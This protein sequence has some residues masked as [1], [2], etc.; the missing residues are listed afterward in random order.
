MTRRRAFRRFAAAT[1]AAVLAMVATGARA[2]SGLSSPVDAMEGLGPVEHHPV[3]NEKPNQLYHVLVRAPES[4]PAGALYPTVYPAGRRDH[5]PPALGVLP[6]PAPGG[7]G[8]RAD[9]RGHLVRDRRLARR[10]RAQPRLHGPC[11]GR[12]PLGWCGGVPGRAQE[13]DL[14]AG[15]ERVPVGSGAPHRLRPVAGRTV[16]PQCRVEGPRAVLGPRRQQP[17]AAPQPGALFLEPAVPASSRRVFVSSGENDDPRF[18]EPARAW[19]AHWAGQAQ[20]PFDLEVVTLRGQTH[21]SAAP[22][23]FREGLRWIFS[24]P[25]AAEEYFAGACVRP[26]RLVESPPRRKRAR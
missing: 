24:T 12:G 3:R 6:L 2:G 9:P 20:R 17:R 25:Q 21:F 5:V 13:A 8:S 16:R 4:P 14:P 10:E 26:T 7:R 18:R 15:R 1:A 23:A 22:A 11:T 19:M